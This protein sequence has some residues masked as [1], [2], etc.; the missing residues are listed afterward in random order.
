M[1]CMVHCA[2]QTVQS[3]LL[4]LLLICCCWMYIHHLP[5]YS[6]CA[7]LLLHAGVMNVTPRALTAAS[8]SS[9]CQLTAL[10]MSK[11]RDLFDDSLKCIAAH[12]APYNL[13]HLDLSY[14]HEISDE[15]MNYLIQLRHLTYLS[16]EHCQRLT[17]DGIQVLIASE[18]PLRHLNLNW[19]H[20]KNAAVATI[21]V[22]LPDIEV[23]LLWGCHMIGA[24]GLRHLAGL[25]K[26]RYL[27]LT[28]TTYDADQIKSTK[29][30]VAKQQLKGWELWIRRVAVT[31]NCRRISLEG[32]MAN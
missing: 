16:L 24:L 6:G 4:P 12:F 2:F 20:L 8:P 7:F 3:V 30:S 5:A 27:D 18:P 32:Y 23:L 1:W 17:S 11:C 28:G 26:W 9:L 29:C 10:T 25:S 15:S 31:K 22:H 13:C 19:C 14:C 21:A